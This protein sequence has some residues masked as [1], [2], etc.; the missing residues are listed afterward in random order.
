MSEAEAT[1]QAASTEAEAAAETPMENVEDEDTVRRIA[2]PH[3]HDL[4]SSV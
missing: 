1:A 2:T 3:G 4:V